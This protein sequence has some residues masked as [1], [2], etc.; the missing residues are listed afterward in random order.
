MKWSLNVF[1]GA[2]STK[3]EYLTVLIF[4]GS[5]NWVYQTH[6]KKGYFP[7]KKWIVG[8][9]CKKVTWNTGL[10]SSLGVK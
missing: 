10:L 6:A 8:T 3:P 5:L 2:K 9:Y 7:R 1:F 4:F